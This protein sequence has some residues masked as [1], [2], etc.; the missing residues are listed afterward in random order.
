MQPDGR[1]SHSPA[2]SPWRAHEVDDLD[3]V[4]RRIGVRHRHDRGETTERGGSAPGLD[5]LG[6]LAARL[7]QVHVQVDE[8]RTDHAAGGIEHLVVGIRW[9]GV[10]DGTDRTVG[11]S[12]RRR[13]RSPVASMIL[14]P[15]MSRLIRELLASWLVIAA[16]RQPSRSNRTAMRTAMP[17]VTCW[18]MTAP[19]SSAGST[20]IST[21]R[22]IGPGCITSVCGASR[23]A[24]SGVRPKRVVYSRRLG[25]SASFIRSCCMR[26]RYSTSMS[27]ITSSRRSVTATGEAFARV[28]RQQCAWRHDGDM[29]AEQ[30]ERRDRRCVRPGCA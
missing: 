16:S 29:G 2:R 1:T 26:R 9:D 24:R 6:L 3:A 28:G 7:A 27:A 13:V 17:L 20:A 10:A 19:G 5:R 21:P 18:V 22:F 4:L 8:A 15:V 23:A 12:A 25:T 11:R 30:A 14:A